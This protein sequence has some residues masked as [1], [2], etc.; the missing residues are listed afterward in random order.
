MNVYDSMSQIEWRFV[1][2]TEE[3]LFF[4]A[5]RSV[6]VE[7]S[8]KCD[9]FQGLVFSSELS[10]RSQWR[11]VLSRKCDRFKDWFSVANYQLRSQCQTVT[12][13]LFCVSEE[14]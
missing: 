7:H 1:L 3:H 9:V 14:V 6:L 13:F 12:P 5:P 8:R 11:F 2:R 10:L 4:C